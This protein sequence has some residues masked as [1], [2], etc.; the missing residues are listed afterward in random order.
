MPPSQTG[1]TL[2]MESVPALVDRVVSLDIDTWHPQIPPASSERWATA[3]EEGKVLCLSGLPFELSDREKAF[4][5]ASWLSGKRKNISL[6]GDRVA[7]AG[8][9]PDTMAGMGAMIKRY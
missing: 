2:L 5:S 1:E 4:L 9:T 7:G 8:G 3:L 6:D